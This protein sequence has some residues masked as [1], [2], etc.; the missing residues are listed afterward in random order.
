[1]KKGL[2]DEATT[3]MVCMCSFVQS[4]RN[5]RMAL[6]RKKHY[7]ILKLAYTLYDRLIHNE[8]EYEEVM[9]Y[10]KHIYNHV[11]DFLE[12]NT[13]CYTEMREYE[14]DEWEKKITR[15]HQIAKDAAAV[16]IYSCLPVAQMKYSFGMH[17]KLTKVE[18]LVFHEHIP[19]LTTYEDWNICRDG[20]LVTISSI[21]T[22]SCRRCGVARA[23][24]RCKKC[25]TTRYCSKACW[26]ANL[27]TKEECDIVK[28]W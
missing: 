12:Y 20:S 4:D 14:K 16:L 2:F 6:K 1:M 28:Q 7:V 18:R 13:A 8:I 27:H 11:L 23:K 21:M 15:L 19:W 3:Q 26:H 9:G 5:Y 22:G 24:L 17:K 10:E 25:K